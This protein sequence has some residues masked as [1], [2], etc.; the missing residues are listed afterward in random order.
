MKFIEGNDIFASLPTGY[1]KSMIYG[2]LPDIFNKLRGKTLVRVCV[3]C[4]HN[5]TGCIIYKKYS[6]YSC[7][8]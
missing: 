8:H 2:L 1:G 6:K 5:H 3:D 4:V 7:L